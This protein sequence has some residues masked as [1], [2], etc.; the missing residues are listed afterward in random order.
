MI[1]LWLSV[2]LWTCCIVWL[3]KIV[4]EGRAEA[5]RVVENLQPREGRRKVSA[6]LSPPTPW[7][8]EVTDQYWGSWCPCRLGLEMVN[9]FE[10]PA[11][12][13]NGFC[14]CWMWVVVFEWFMMIV[15]FMILCVMPR[16]GCC[17]SGPGSRCV[18]GQGGGSFGLFG[19]NFWSLTA[20]A[21]CGTVWFGFAR[22]A[23]FC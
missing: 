12:W 21:V 7:A 1:S 4:S 22:P 8:F 14:A 3:L 23:W 10:M 20:Q 5:C 19:G 11:P 18:W 15:Y 17:V 9:V 6:V 2:F 13:F 16:N